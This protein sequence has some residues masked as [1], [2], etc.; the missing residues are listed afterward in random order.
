MGADAARGNLFTKLIREIQIAAKNGGDPSMN[1]RLRTAID[2]AKAENMPNDNIERAIKRGTGQ[3]EGGTL[4]E[5]TYEGYGPNGVA[6][7]VDAVTDNRNRTTSEIKHILSRH[8]GTLGGQGSVAWQ[9]VARGLISIDAKKYDEDTVITLALDGGASD[10]KNDG[11][12]Y[13]IIT[14]PES[15]NKIKELLKT[16][17]IEILSSEL[18]KV[19]QNTVPIT[20]KDAEKILRLFEALDEL[21]D[22]QHV[23]GN[24]DIP[25]SVMEK[26]STQGS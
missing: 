13:Q 21:E 18:A 14:P 19:P 24:F 10:V 22:V 17:K 3:L 12:T 6:I 5:V 11:E 26:I 2:T 4:E 16:N 7:L 20:E 15:H 25:D 8:N 1:P 9:F 23:Y